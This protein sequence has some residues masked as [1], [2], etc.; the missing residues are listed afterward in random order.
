MLPLYYA[1]PLRHAMLII[2]LPCP[3]ELL[4]LYFSLRLMPRHFAI[5]PFSFF[6]VYGCLIS[7]M[8]LIIFRC[9]APLMMRH[10]EAACRCYFDA[11]ADAFFCR[12]T[13]F[14]SLRF[15]A[16]A[17]DTLLLPPPPPL[18]RLP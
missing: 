8:P 2:Y 1:L 14:S 15:D 16:A 13:L 3:L 17:A 12:H 18:M 5:T 6:A 4:M 9:Y 11:D 10:F 7:P